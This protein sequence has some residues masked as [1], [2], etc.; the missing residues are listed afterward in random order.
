MA[1]RSL[2][3]PVCLALRCGALSIR[4]SDAGHRG[5]RA[6]LPAWSGIDEFAVARELR[7]N[8]HVE[9]EEDGIGILL[10]TQGNDFSA[11]RARMHVDALVY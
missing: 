11:A 7:R 6:S 8:G 1:I 10:L 3:Q 2:R 9:I 5:A 4:F